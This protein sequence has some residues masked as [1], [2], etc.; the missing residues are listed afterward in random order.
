MCCPFPETYTG[1]HLNFSLLEKTSGKNVF[2]DKSDEFGLSELAQFWLAG[3]MSHARGMT[4]VIC[5]N[6]NS[7]ERLAPGQKSTSIRYTIVQDK[8]NKTLI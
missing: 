1:V 8:G 6:N 5:P 4:A 3:V 7:Y 2:T